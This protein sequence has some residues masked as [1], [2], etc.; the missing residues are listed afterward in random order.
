VIVIALF[1]NRWKQSSI[2]LRY[3]QTKNNKNLIQSSWLEHMVNLS[4]LDIQTPCPYLQWSFPNLG[5]SNLWKILSS[6]LKM[7]H[8]IRKRICEPWRR[9]LNSSWLDFSEWFHQIK[10]LWRFT[11]LMLDP[12]TYRQQWRYLHHEYRH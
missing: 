1:Y 6:S 4:K 11:N 10:R 7:E 5:L 3:A 9:R 12:R 8:H 2:T